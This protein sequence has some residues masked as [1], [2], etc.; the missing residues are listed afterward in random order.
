VTA[1]HAPR[2]QVLA[3]AGARILPPGRLEAFSD[4]VFAIAITLL[5]IELHV[6]TSKEAL[7]AGL[8]HEWPRY[9][10]Y[11][12]SFAFIGGVWLAH[13]NLTRFIRVVDG[14]LMRLN[15]L[16]LLFVSLLPFTTGVVANHLFVSYFAVSSDISRS[17]SGER[18][19]VVLFGMDL[20]LAALMLYLLIRHAARVPG[21][22]VDD[23]AEEELQRFAAERRAAFVAQASATVVGVFLPILAVLFY[24]SVSVLFIVAPLTS[25]RWR[26]AQPPRPAAGGDGARR[27]SEE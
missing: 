21:I 7:V 4:G 3:V 25:T 22:A 9:L 13:S 16:L 18:V 1:T 8:E 27:A 15:L 12:V 5:V 6:P 10:G 14:P 2:P 19:A 24:L 20:M 26:R 11:L 23:V 17:F